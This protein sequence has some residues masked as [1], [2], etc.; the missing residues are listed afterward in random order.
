MRIFRYKIVKR[1][2]T[3]STLERIALMIGAVIAS[4]LISSILIIQVNINPFIAY[5]ELFRG[6][7][8]SR[9]ALS[10]TL[11]RFIPLCF[12]GIAVALAFLGR[13]WNIGAEGQLYLGALFAT[14]FGI[15]FY[16][17]SPFVLIPLMI[18]A[19][20][21]GGSLAAL[22]P[23]ILRSKYQVD[24]VV[25]T[26][27]LNWIILFIVEAIIYGPWRNPVSAWPE[28]P[29]ISVTGELPRIWRGTR[30]HAGLIIALLVALIYYIIYTRSYWG[31]E[32]KLMGINPKA[33]YVQGMD[34]VRNLILVALISG[35]IAGI[36]GA[37][38]LMGIHFHL[39]ENLSLG[40]GYTGIV[41]AMLGL[42]H[43]IGVVLAAFFMA[44]IETGSQAMYRATGIPYPLAYVIEGVTLVFVL[45]AVFFM[46]Y[47]LEKVE[48]E[49]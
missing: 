46:E 11:V 39:R 49:R 37:V 8:G 14:V 20:F 22:I 7:W 28:S 24:E 34:V 15:S 23:A 44:T 29:A 33:A 1:I 38:E 6:A 30:L 3:P 5:Y 41:V 18:L 10:E 25:T 12:T 17:V 27:L 16:G 42:L 47:R 31:F 26:L 40:Y 21:L 19:G 9:L 45:I 2:E 13:F 36:S 4:I 32:V 35:G 43:P 48:E